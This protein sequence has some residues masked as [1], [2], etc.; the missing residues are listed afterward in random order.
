MSDSGIQ[1]IRERF[2]YTRCTN[3]VSLFKTQ[4]STS[5]VV[6][7]WC[8]DNK[9]RRFGGCHATGHSIA[10]L[11]NISGRDQ[12]VQTAFLKNMYFMA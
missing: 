12:E 3:P 11:L 5:S 2:N 10:I 9:A 7:E 6:L 1:P 8:R 4:T